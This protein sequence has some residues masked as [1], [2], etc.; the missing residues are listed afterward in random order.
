VTA[1]NPA[2]VF[3]C[4]NKP[5]FAWTWFIK[6]QLTSLI[7]PRPSA[8]NHENLFQAGTKRKRAQAGVSLRLKVPKIHEGLI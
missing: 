1:S 8:L 6:Q 3:L 5:Q 7:L 4:V 2:F